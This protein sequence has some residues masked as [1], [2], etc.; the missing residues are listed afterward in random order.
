M[1]HPTN[2]KYLSDAYR[3][4]Y[5]RQAAQERLAR[6]VESKSDGETITSALAALAR[7]LHPPAARPVVAP[8]PL[9]KKPRRASA[10]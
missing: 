6:A 7:I 3:H 8:P 1:I 4:E 10:I 5:E 2:A 9:L